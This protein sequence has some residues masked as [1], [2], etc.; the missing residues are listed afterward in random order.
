M[1]DFTLIFVMAFLLWAW[2]NLHARRI[3]QQK[4]MEKETRKILIERFKYKIETE[5][6]QEQADMAPKKID[7]AE[8]STGRFKMNAYPYLQQER[9]CGKERRKS[10]IK[11][12]IVFEYIDRRKADSALYI[13]T[14]K[15]SGM[16]RRGK[17]WDRRK[18]KLP[19]RVLPI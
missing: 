4:M 1:K 19:L 9:R 13:D 18:P 2:L 15:R 12:G 8:Q 5:K 16:D 11:V 6:K 7:G 17:V 10:R 14:E 3:G